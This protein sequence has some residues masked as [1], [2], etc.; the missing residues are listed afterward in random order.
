[1]YSRAD[2]ALNIYLDTIDVNQNRAL[3]PV[4]RN[5]P[6]PCIHHHAESL[7][8]TDQPIGPAAEGALQATGGSGDAATSVATR[9]NNAPA[10]ATG[11]E[12][13]V[14]CLGFGLGLTTY[15]FICN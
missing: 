1:M 4:S 6:K 7:I 8:L 9:C 2:L 3:L 11:L 14:H 15:Y 10:T 13:S 12:K 5:T